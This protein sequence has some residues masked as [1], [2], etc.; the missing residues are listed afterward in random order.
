MLAEHKAGSQ[1]SQPDH[2]V[3]CARSGSAL[4]RHYIAREVRRT[5]KRATLPSGKAAFPILHEVDADEK[6]VKVPRGAV[7]TFHSFRHVVASQVIAEGDSAEEASWLLGHK[8]STVTRCV[9][10]TEIKSVERS[11]KRRAKMEARLGSV[12]SAVSARSR[13]E[14]AEAANPLR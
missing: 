4:D 7:P 10:V 1:W 3:F 12:M 5:L 9:Y 11:S 13:N 8:D 14:R 2:F 6:P